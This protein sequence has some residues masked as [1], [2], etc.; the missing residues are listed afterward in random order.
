MGKWWTGA[1]GFRQDEE[2]AGY[3]AHYLWE[4]LEGTSVSGCAIQQCM[5]FERFQCGLDVVL[6]GNVLVG[7]RVRMKPLPDFLHHFGGR[8]WL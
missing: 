4:E 6:G 1:G 3:F 2:V 5:V 8:H 7:G